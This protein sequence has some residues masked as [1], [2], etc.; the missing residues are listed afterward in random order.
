VIHV[1]RGLAFHYRA[2]GGRGLIRKALE[3]LRRMIWS[4]TCWFV[5][6]R[7][8][9]D[10]S[11]E[12]DELVARRQLGLRELAEVGYPKLKAYPEQIRRRF[13]EGNVCFGFFV[14]E[15]LATIGWSSPGY[16]EL[17]R[18]CRIPCRGAVGLYDFET[19]KDFRSR[20]YY[21]NALMQIAKVE[22]SA[23]REALFIAVDPG[24]TPS[25]RGIERAGF[26]RV[27]CVRRRRR[28]G[29]RMITQCPESD[30]A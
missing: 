27:A 5:Y 20:G 7:L 16:L 8:A 9:I 28:F 1:L 26:Q 12:V 29:V 10:E 2:G 15:R 25:I 23:R 6:S 18:D 4:D 11:P 24:N 3:Y 19:L 21:T 30:D 14:G 13:S 17:D 22:G